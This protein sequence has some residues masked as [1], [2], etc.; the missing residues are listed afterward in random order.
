MSLTA[1]I[2]FIAFGALIALAAIFL[3]DLGFFGELI[4]SSATSV[5]ATILAVMGYNFAKSTSVSISDRA[6]YSILGAIG[7]VVISLIWR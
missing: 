5:I 2:L 7:M 4:I 1:K 6:V 3:G